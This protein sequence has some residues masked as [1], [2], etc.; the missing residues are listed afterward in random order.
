MAVLLDQYWIC[1]LLDH[2]ISHATK[3]QQQQ[4]LSIIKLCW[5]V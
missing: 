4:Q 3:R 1:T 2:V 5:H